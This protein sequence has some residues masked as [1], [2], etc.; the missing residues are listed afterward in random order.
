MT[1][2]SPVDPA[3]VLSGLSVTEHEPLEI[4][5]FRIS[6]TVRPRD[7]NDLARALSELQGSGAGLLIQGG[8][9][10]L[11]RGNLP[12]RA[13]LILATDAL[14]GID[15]FDCNDG[16]M[17]VQGGTPL[18]EVEAAAAVE[19]WEVPL[20]PPG[21]H[22]TVGGILARAGTGP[23]E[24][25]WGPVRDCVLGLDV[26]LPG[27]VRTHCGGRV[28]KNVTGFDLAKLYTGSLGALGVIDG[29]WLR[30]KPSAEV[31]HVFH[32]WGRDRIRVLDGA[33]RA[34]R[35]ITARAVAV[36]SPRAASHIEGEDTDAWHWWIELAGEL[37]AVER[38]AN[39]LL[40]EN[41]EARKIFGGLDEVRAFQGRCLE[42]NGL[43]ARLDLVPTD[44]VKV[45][46]ALLETAPGQL[47]YPGSGTLYAYSDA[48]GV[49]PAERA[50]LGAARSVEGQRPRSRVCLEA[51]PTVAKA[52]RDVF[53]LPAGERALL[54]ALKRRFDPEALLNPGRGPGGL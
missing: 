5:G 46:A 22:A 3:S 34:S 21:E 7:A 36:A 16:V 4:D 42:P 26:V 20:D 1:S 28:V 54:E 52:G 11:E 18:S 35:W 6:S 51:L 15:E 2:G 8:G 41:P 17:H 45:S 47:V 31:V 30:L 44:L 38:D 49:R 40:D 33:V 14:C 39:G 43:R 27:G 53:F 13:D 32:G 10:A 50:C 29:A 12:G 19:G 23:R 24:L 25:G 48:Q 9:T 37:A